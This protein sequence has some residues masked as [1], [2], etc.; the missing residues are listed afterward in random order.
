MKDVNSYMGIISVTII[1]D[2]DSINIITGRLK[3]ISNISVKTA[4][5]EKT[6]K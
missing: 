4:I 5:S 1:A 2:M 6:V 3:Q